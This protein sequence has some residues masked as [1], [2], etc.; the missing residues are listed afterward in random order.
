MKL[1]AG[2]GSSCCW[3][4]GEWPTPHGYRFSV[5]RTGL[6]AG[7]TASR[8]RRSHGAACAERL[9]IW[10]ASSADR[11]M[12]V[13]SDPTQ[14]GSLP[15]KSKSAMTDATESPSWQIRIRRWSHWPSLGRTGASSKKR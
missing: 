8:F 10:H 5:G 14:E 4:G 1:L 11:G 15:G 6:E 12:T 2:S 9:A 3:D 7:W 13:R